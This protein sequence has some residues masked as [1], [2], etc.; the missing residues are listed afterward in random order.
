M[1]KMCPGAK[2]FME[3]QS[4]P[5]TF[6][7]DPA[8]TGAGESIPEGAGN[9]RIVRGVVSCLRRLAIGGK[10]DAGLGPSGG[11]AC[12]QGRKDGRDLSFAL[13]LD[14]FHQVFL[15]LITSTQ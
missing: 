7:L 9:G 6:D 14:R 1:P 12:A 10:D 5:L 4:A 3:A 8:E 13:D 11:R 15:R 2:M